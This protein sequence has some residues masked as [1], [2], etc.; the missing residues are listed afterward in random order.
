MSGKRYKDS[1]VMV[2][3][4]QYRNK[5]EIS[6]YTVLTISVLMLLVV[7]IF[8]GIRSFE[9]KARCFQAAALV[10]EEVK[11]DYQ[12]DLFRRYHLLAVDRTYYGRGEAYMEERIKSNLEYNLNSQHSLYSF[13][14]NNADVVETKT[15]MDD[16]L[17]GMKRQIA[18]YMEQKLPIDVAGELFENFK[19]KEDQNIDELWNLASE[20]SANPD[21][22]IESLSHPDK[23]YLEDIGILDALVA[24][25]TENIENLSL[26]DI[27]RINQ[28]KNILTDP[29]QELDSLHKSGVI[30]L[31]MPDR[32]G[33]VSSEKI[34]LSGV[35]SASYV[36]EDKTYE[37]PVFSGIED[38]KNL[39]G[40]ISMNKDM[41]GFDV[42]GCSKD[43]LIGIAYALDS[44]QSAQDTFYEADNE[45]HAFEYELE[46]ILMGKSSDAENVS[47]VANQLVLLRL[48]PNV[49]YAFSNKEMKA[50]TTLAAAII[51]IPIDCEFLIKPVS[52]VFL[53]CWAYGE[54]I[55][56]VKQLFQGE[57]VAFV[58]DE[59]SWNLSLNGLAE[60]ALPEKQ[61]ETQIGINYAEYMAFLLATMPDSNQKYYRMLDI[62]EL[63]IQNDI[64]E[65]EIEN[66]IYEYQLQFQ[67]EEGGYTWYVDGSGTFIDE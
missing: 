53:A 7:V 26:D 36:K 31:V 66:C 59:K 5:G 52:Y 23:K 40:L 39:I 47:N 28:E 4:R 35:P 51:L 16:S 34:D 25:E 38:I 2:S 11:G 37:L 55:F 17:Y 65:F 67:I 10:T 45:Y 62:M 32:A 12:P 43:D 33:T 21:L 57:R 29:R 24:E 54:S 20:D 46:Y 49:L 9:A 50:E 61:K 14:V 15:L 19:N 60:L 41:Q 30:N 22:D 44:F 27:I 18:E 64:P 42:E 3:A 1:N 13:R 48:I 6:V 63:N 58:K 56:D 8:H